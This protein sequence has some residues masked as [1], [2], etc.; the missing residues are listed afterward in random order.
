MG[1]ASAFH[2]QTGDALVV[3][4]VQRDFL[5]GGSL[6]VMRGEE[7]VELLNEYIAAFKRRDLLVVAT[8]DWHPANHCSFQAQGGPWPPH[9]IAGTEG[10]RFAPG[11][12]LPEDVLIISKASS[13]ESEAYSSFE[14]TELDHLLREAGIRRVFVGGLTTDYCVLNTVRDAVRLGYATVLLGDAIRAVNVQ[15]GDGARALE[16]MVRLGAVQIDQDRF[17]G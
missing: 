5:T 8:R 13:A 2:L 16:E 14:G 1:H 4:D 9:C 11:L 10:A 17:A 7:V 15:P 12:D 6:A 3:T